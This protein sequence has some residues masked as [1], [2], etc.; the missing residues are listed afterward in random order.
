[1]LYIIIFIRVLKKFHYFLGLGAHAPAAVVGA[2]KR[3][4]CMRV[5]GRKRFPASDEQEIEKDAT[6]VTFSTHLIG[7]YSDRP[8]HRIRQP[9]L[10]QFCRISLPPRS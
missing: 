5:H 9:T 6:A 3:R 7:V 4:A 10:V 2:G 8:S 1:M